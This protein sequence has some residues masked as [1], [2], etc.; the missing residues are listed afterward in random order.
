M[1]ISSGHTGSMKSNHSPDTG[2]RRLAGIRT[3]LTSVIWLGLKLAKTD[4]SSSWDSRWV[5]KN[6]KSQEGGSRVD[7][8]RVKVEEE[9]EMGNCPICIPGPRW[10]GLWCKSSWSQ[11]LNH[12]SRDYPRRAPLRQNYS[13]F[14]PLN[15]CI[16]KRS[17]KGTWKRRLKILWQV[18]AQWICQ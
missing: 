9:V 12:T 1:S 18:P 16:Q 15:W 13:V 8:P 7:G 4:S 11:A 3:R 17:R 14:T 2:P 5:Q 10:S 6:K